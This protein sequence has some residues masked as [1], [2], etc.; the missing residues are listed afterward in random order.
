MRQ[1]IGSFQISFFW[2][3]GYVVVVATTLGVPLAMG[4]LVSAGG[5]PP[6]EELLVG[7]IAG[8]AA[9]EV[10]SFLG[11]LAIL[12]SVKFFVGPDDLG[13]VNRRGIYHACAWADIYSVRCVNVLGL[14]Y[15]RIYGAEG[16]LLLCLPLFLSERDRF[17]QFVYQYAGANHPLALAIHGALTA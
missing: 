9:G 11:L 6:L 10:F 1:E 13:W 3:L 15:L 4:I 16:R 14:K 8:V 12:P 17:A 5:W 2:L 7:V